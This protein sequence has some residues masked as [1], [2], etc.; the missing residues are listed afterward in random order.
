VT[1]AHRAARKAV[2]D[3]EESALHEAAA[4][5][6]LAVGVIGGAEFTKL[7]PGLDP[8][9][10]ATT[11]G[12]LLH[13]Q[14]IPLTGYGLGTRRLISLAIQEE[15]FTNG[16]I[17]VVDEVEHGL[18]PHRLQHL[19]HHLKTRTAN[20]KGQ[21][22]LTT[23]SPMAV[24]SLIAADISVVRSADGITSVMPVPSEVDDVQGTLR[25]APSALLAKN[26]VVCEGKTEMGVVRRLIQHWDEQ[27]APDKPS[28]A[29]MGVAYSCGEGT[30]APK[31]ASVFRLLGYPTLLVVDNDDSA[32]DAMVAAVIAKGGRIV[33]WESGNAMEQQIANSL[34]LAGLKDMV[35]LAAAFKSEEAVISAVAARL[36]GN[37][38]LT[39]LDP[40]A[41]VAAGQALPAVR[42]AIGA[43]AKKKDWFKMEEPG[44]QLAALLVSRWDEIKNLPLGLGFRQVYAFVYGEGMP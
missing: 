39:G 11:H 4:D 20:N 24:E 2:F 5:V 21:V 37:P 29:S 41:W 31:R 42:A 8:S 44:S 7:R 3:F 28:H 14:E 6:A 13:E 26:V 33:R 36:D 12:L 38:K 40:A 15:A 23:H 18:E 1:S 10:G 35:A 22:I 34:S 16:E 17:V 9:S 32:I 27:R 19:L 25:A 30:T 43:A